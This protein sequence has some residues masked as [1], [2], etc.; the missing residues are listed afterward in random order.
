MNGDGQEMKRMGEPWAKYHD[1]KGSFDTEIRD[2][3]SIAIEDSCNGMHQ[4][5][6]PDKAFWDLHDSTMSAFAVEDPFS[7]SSPGDCILRTPCGTQFKVFR[8]VL[9]IASPV[10]KTMFNLPQPPTHAS[11]SGDRDFDPPVIDVTE[12]AEAIQVLLKIF[13]PLETVQI[14]SVDLVIALVDACEKYELPISRVMAASQ[15]VFQNLGSYDIGDIIKVHTLTWRL[16]MEEEAKRASRY[17]HH[18]DLTKV[19]TVQKLITPSGNLLPLVQLY[20]LRTRREH[21]IRYIMRQ[22]NPQQYFCDRHNSS[23]DKI[24]DFEEL[25]RTALNDPYPTCTDL[26]T[27]LSR[28]IPGRGTLS[29]RSGCKGK[30]ACFGNTPF[31]EFTDNDEKTSHMSRLVSN[32]PQHITWVRRHFHPE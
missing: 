9:Q 23:A 30:S 32:H 11:Q 26:M 24:A 2:R 27:F 17:M 10:F 21:N 19:A 8:V 12:T 29:P 22:F 6:R 25:L 28:S 1:Y 18:V 5:M 13:Y 31:A 7:A 16:N 3:P 15:Y 20:D 14:K 4:M